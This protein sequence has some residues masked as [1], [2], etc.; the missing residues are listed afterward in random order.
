MASGMRDLLRSDH[1][2]FWRQGIPGLFLTDTADFRYPHYH[3]PADTI[4]KVDFNFLTKICKAI[5][6]TATS[7]K[8]A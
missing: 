2:P 3:T 6:A 7:L 8:A 5:V 1:A 4:D